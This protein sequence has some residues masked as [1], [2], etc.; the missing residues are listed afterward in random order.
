MEEISNLVN[1]GNKGNFKVQVQ[2]SGKAG[3]FKQ[4]S[5]NINQLMS[6]TDNGLE[7]VQRILAALEKGDLSQRI[8]NQYFGA[9]NRLKESA[10]NTAS[11]MQ[12]VIGE[13]SELVNNANQGKFDNVIQLEG[14]SGFFADLSNSLNELM[15]T[16]H[17]GFDDALR[18]LGALEQG[19]LSQ[20]IDGHHKGVFKRLQEY[21]GSTVQQIKAILEEISRLIAAA[22]HGDFSHRILLDEKPGFYKDLSSSLNELVQTTDAGLND[23]IVLLAALSEG[24]LSKKIT[25]QY[26]GSFGKLKDDANQTIDKL[27]E[28]IKQIN[29]SAET[30][31]KDSQEIAYGNADLNQRTKQ[32][33]SS[34]EQTASNMDKLYSTV[35][36]NSD[37]A[38]EAHQIALQATEKAQNGVQVATDA[39]DSM[40][41]IDA[42]SSHISNIITVIDEIAFQTNLLALNAAVEA[43]RAGEQGRGF[44]VVAGEVRNLAQR[45]STAAK[46]IKELINISVSKV[47]IGT[48]FVNNTGET[49]KDIVRS[50]SEVNSKISDINTASLEQTNGIKKIN[51][52]VVT[53]DSVTQQTVALVSQAS[54]SASSAAE[55]AQSMIAHLSFFQHYHAS[56]VSDENIITYR[57][58]Q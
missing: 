53:I 21:S 11:Q 10:N 42:A 17:Q 12:R 46:E 47:K 37:K 57:A 32:Q 36:Q 6:T 58:A 55:Q 30:V 33:A 34:L 54:S 35:K 25:G 56:N 43:A 38:Q 9:F 40:K 2:L 45:S 22:S 3:F 31:A 13:I 48:E 27:T 4:L 39:I 52:A 5:I 44:A 16:T 23:I 28:I 26:S 51:E 20:T 15:Q 24:D 8:D 19:D 29:L 1:E 14:K 49:L 18:I 7:D 41:E 50:V